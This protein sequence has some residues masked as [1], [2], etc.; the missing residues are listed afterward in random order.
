MPHFLIRKRVRNRY[1]VGHILGVILAVAITGLDL[2]IAMCASFSD[3]NWVSLS[4]LPGAGGGSPFT[5]VTA[6]LANTNAGLIY[7]GGRF[8]AVG[9]NLANNIAA[10]NGTNWSAFG[11]GL[12]NTSGFAV[13]A[14]ALDG[15][16]NLYVGGGFSY[17]G[18]LP[19][20]NIAKWDGTNWSAIG[21]GLNGSVTAVAVD[22]SGNL[23]AG[24]SFTMAGTVSV[25]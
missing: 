16:G 2:T 11:L 3:A 14:L 20:T 6:V 9:T 23:Y 5:L 19:A 25:P 7:I 17:A 22:G 13:T 18:G 8:T 10:W 21:S 4:G 1:T 15:A 24:G 12:T